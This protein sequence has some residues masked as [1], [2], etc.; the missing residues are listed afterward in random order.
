MYEIFCRL[1]EEKNLK[2]ADV[3]K[4]T[5]IQESFFSNW[6]KK[7]HMINP[8]QAILIADYLGVS[9]DYLYRGKDSAKKSDSGR[10][11]YFSDAAAE[12]AETIYKRKELNDLFSIVKKISAK[13][14]TIIIHTASSFI[15]EGIFEYTDNNEP[16][17][18][19]DGSKSSSAVYPNLSDM[20][21]A[22]DL[23]SERNRIKK[24]GSADKDRKAE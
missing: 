18:V 13:G 9:L 19:L 17:P 4:A 12:I 6:K 21:E 20:Q 7:Q 11:Y 16:Y 22:S 8:E 10:D 3:S 5:G 23:E 1:L 2:P 24:V 15:D 14:I